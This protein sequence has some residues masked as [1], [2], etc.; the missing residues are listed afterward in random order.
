[1]PFGHKLPHRLALLK[2]RLLRGALLALPLAFVASCE[3]PISVNEP[4]PTVAQLVVSPK[5]VTLQ[6]NQV[7]DFLAV[8]YTATGDT[9]DISVTWSATVGT[10]DTSSNGKRH[11]GHFKSGSCGP[12]KLVAKSHPGDLT[13]T[14]TITVS[15]P[16]PVATV[17]VTP[18]SASVLAGQTVQLTAIPLDANG[19]PLSGRVVTWSSDNATV[20]SV[21]ASGVVTANVVGSAT[22]TATSEGQSATSS[23]TVTGVP[24]A[25]VTVAPATVSVSV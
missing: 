5:V 1:M 20:A 3:Q 25:S 19:N 11:Y 8:G 18:A 2:D 24:V 21:S 4:N 14:A 16:T 17:S 6:P 13:D 10:V 9:A 22:I 7:Q 12:A 15:C 23:I